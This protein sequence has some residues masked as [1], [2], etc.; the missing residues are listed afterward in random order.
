M[1]RIPL[2]VKANLL[3]QEELVTIASGSSNSIKVK[4]D[5]DPNSDFADNMLTKR[6]IFRYYQGSYF[7]SDV[8]ANGEVYVPKFVIA[9]PYFKVALRAESEN[10]TAVVTT[11]EIQ[12]PVEK[13]PVF[14]ETTITDG[15]VTI[16]NLDGALNIY[17]AGDVT[18]I[19]FT[20]SYKSAVDAVIAGTYATASALD[21]VA[22]DVDL[23]KDDII[24]MSTSISDLQGDIA[25][26]DTTK[27]DK[28]DTYNK[29]ETDT[30][31]A[32]K[33]DAL[34]SGENIKT[35][36]GV[37]LVGSG[38]YA[39]DS[40]FDEESTNAVQNKVISKEVKE[41]NYEVAVLRE[42]VFEVVLSEI[43]YSSVFTDSFVIPD[44][45]T[46]T[47]GTHRVVFSETELK[48]V[49]GNSVVANQFCNFDFIGQHNTKGIVAKG[50]NV[51]IAV[52]NGYGVIQSLTQFETPIPTGHKVLCMLNKRSGVSS[53]SIEIGGYH[54]S[55]SSWQGNLSPSSSK[56]LSISTTT[57]TVTDILLFLNN[58][59]NVT[60]AFDF[61]FYY[62][63]LTQ[64]FGSGN[65]PTSVDDVRI[66]W[67]IK[68][69]ESNP[70]YDVGTIKSSIINGLQSLDSNDEVVGTITI[71]PTEIKSAGT[72]QDFIEVV[73]GDIVEG[74]QL[75]N[76]VI[77]TD[78]GSAIY[79]GSENKGIDILKGNNGVFRNLGSYTQ[80]Y[81]QFAQIADCAS[82]SNSLYPSHAISNISINSSNVETM[83]IS[84]HNF[85]GIKWALL[86]LPTTTA[87][88]AG[89]ANAWLRN[90][91]VTVQ[92]PLAT[93]FETTLATNLHFSEI[94]ML[95]AE[96]G[97]IK[98]LYDNVPVDTTLTFVVKKAISE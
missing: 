12:V 85:Q 14:Y 55:P 77:T 94:S 47:D 25:G 64:M 27:A 48:K 33:Q 75:Y 13:S 69:L 79:D 52:R 36:N 58:P 38:N 2:K 71:P 83:G 57:N 90:N 46:D 80:F 68:Y 31:L 8:D 62:A 43:D 7:I 35:I 26:L 45:L 93:P 87:S 50:Q 97:T 60:E 88:T 23:I 51:K 3:T 56:K 29:T 66:Q 40:A 84:M 54:M 59:T 20:A 63:D 32:S 21:L 34:V 78:V 15:D 39:F 82:Y 6:A 24:N 86:T 37:S 1:I 95:I 72:A 16:R 65:E 10:A 5:I 18:F 28:A 19:D 11:N 61:D 89:Q 4:F 76:L 42:A 67:L 9:Y 81:L 53:G 22:S 41:L 30:F 74:E 96:G 70:D 17:K 73:E 98:P 92:Y 91:N 49:A 44:T